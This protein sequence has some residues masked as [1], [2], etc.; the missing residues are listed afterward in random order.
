MTTAGPFRAI[1]F[2]FDY[3]LG[4]SS[5]AA[6]D[7]M[8]FALRGMGLP[9]VDPATCAATIGLALPETL[10]ALAG[11]DQ[12]HR[13]AEFHALFMQRADEVM[14]PWTT[15][16]PFTAP[17]LGG[18]RAAG[19]RIA[20]VSNKERFRIEGILARFG[21]PDVVDA[22]VGAGDVAAPKPAPDSL[23]AAL[24]RLGVAADEALYVGDNTV[25]ARAASAAGITF[26]AV[27]SGHT[28]AE[29]FAP[30]Q[31]LAVLADASGIPALLDG[32]SA[33]AC[34]CPAGAAP[35]K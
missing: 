19:M 8:R 29:A 15:V 33:Q 7:C 27:T 12:A 13:A 16:Y 10:V 23:L 9:D 18:L 30:W 32:Q 24:V 34:D 1:L 35:S 20:I 31:P 14:V 26:V 25:D 3:T 5:P 6:V 2:D 21:L 28:N 22:I 11:T 17:L 4:D